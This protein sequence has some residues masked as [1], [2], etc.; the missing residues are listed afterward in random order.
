VLL[1][2][3]PVVAERASAKFNISRTI[4]ELVGEE[5]RDGDV[6]VI[7]S[8]YIAIS[9]GRVVPL[10]GVTPSVEAR[11]MGI[12]YRMSPRL[13]ELI[14]RESDFVVGGV[15][16]FVLAGRDG[17]LTPNA[18]IDKSN[19]EHGKVVLYP[20][21]PEESADRI[22]EAIRFSRGV[23]VAVVVCDSRLM[24]TRRGTTGVALASSGLESVVDLRGRKDL[25]GKKLKV[26]SQAIADD[27]SSAAELI[28]G[29][30]N[31]SVPIVLVRGLN[32][33]MLGH[34]T[35]SPMDFGVD[36]QGC[37]YLRSLGFSP[38]NSILRGWDA[39]QRR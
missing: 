15:P 17:L 14:L 31:E 25:F 10:N 34:R 28:L 26:T 16:G 4:D 1:A 7:S 30:S 29:E 19:I 37:V 11:S 32:Q 8:K 38:R 22:R 23:E 5:L 9:E 33:R 13:C 36:A 27:L 12:L 18:G 2:L 39:P 24:P 20:R 21:R 6:L 3:R 35:Y